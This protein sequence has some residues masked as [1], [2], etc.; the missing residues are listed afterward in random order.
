MHYCLNGSTCQACDT[1]F[2]LSIKDASLINQLAILPVSFKEVANWPAV[3][4]WAEFATLDVVGVSAYVMQCT[5][6]KNNRTW[7]WKLDHNLLSFT[8]ILLRIR[9]IILF[10]P[11]AR[12]Y[13]KIAELNWSAIMKI[14]FYT[15]NE[16][17]NSSNEQTSKLI[18]T[19][20]GNQPI[21]HPYFPYGHVFC[22]LMVLRNGFWY[23]CL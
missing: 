17:Q 13:H 10:I 19:V 12:Y 1:Q 9:K 23:R 20:G 2:F 11:R 21:K 3:E 5:H 16:L 14:E 4:T 7:S 15:E 18:W 6:D 8:M 22:H